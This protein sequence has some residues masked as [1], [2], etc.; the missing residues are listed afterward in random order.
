[1]AAEKIRI[2]GARQHNLKGIN[3]EIPRDRLVVIAPVVKGETGEFRDVLEKIKREGFVRV[4]LD[5]EIVELGRPEPVRLNKSA[6]HT[7]EV[8]VDRLVMR[9]GVRP[10]LADS[11]D[12]A[13]RW[14]H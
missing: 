9:E 12:T 1:M 13:L 4:R 10:R 2:L 14:G 8:V 5:G 3:V 7:I 11:V 6:R